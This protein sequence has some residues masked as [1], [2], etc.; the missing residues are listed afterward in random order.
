MGC[1]KLRSDKKS[2]VEEQGDYTLSEETISNEVIV[3]Q[4]QVVWQEAEFPEPSSW[5]EESNVGEEL[6]TAESE[7]L[8][9]PK[10]KRND[11]PFPVPDNGSRNDLL[12]KSAHFLQKEKSS[13]RANPTSSGRKRSKLYDTIDR[14]FIDQ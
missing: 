11:T 2:T 5:E 12:S 4:G 6:S 3:E 14:V 7:N 9:L 10:D 13:Q 1:D 8:G